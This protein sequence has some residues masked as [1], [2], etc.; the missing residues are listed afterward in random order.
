MKSKNEAKQY[1]Y[2]K[3]FSIFEIILIILMVVSAIVATFIQGG[4]P[5]G[6]PILL[7]CIVAFC[8]CRSRKIKDESIEQILEKIIQD[9]QITYSD[10]TIVAYDLKNAIVK[11]RKDGKLISPNYYITDIITA[12]DGVIT[13]N[14]YTID[15]INSSV[16]MTSHSVTDNEEII[17]IEETIK[18]NV[19]SA[20]MSYLKINSSCMI[21]VTL[22]DYK[23]S[24][25][26]E[27]ICNR[28]EKN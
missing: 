24:K 8:I 15:L 11:K 14:S 7:V 12:A 13:F 25:V 3:N 27:N 22:N 28:H 16:K 18:T 26:V 19:G 2:Q 21:P 1:F 4:G 6:L 9:N 17:L 10:N 5:I 23:A 20:K